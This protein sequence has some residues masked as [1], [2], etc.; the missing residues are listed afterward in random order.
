M[1]KVTNSI[2]QDKRTLNQSVLFLPIG[3]VNQHRSIFSLENKQAS[4]SRSNNQSF[5]RLSL[6]T[7][8]AAHQRHG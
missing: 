5:P 7:Q 1:F 6:A 2:S 3:I 4:C 8:P